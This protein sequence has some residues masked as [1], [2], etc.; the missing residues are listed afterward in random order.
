MCR[1]PPLYPF[2]TY[3]ESYLTDITFYS[4]TVLIHIFTIIRVLFSGFISFVCH[5]HFLYFS[6][7]PRWP[8]LVFF[9]SMFLV[10]TSL[11][12]AFPVLIFLSIMCLFALLHS[13]L[14]PYRLLT[15]LKLLLGPRIVCNMLIN[16][17]SKSISCYSCHTVLPITLLQSCPFFPVLLFC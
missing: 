10:P 2:H 12:G 8:Y 7:P 11:S 13:C 9:L 15:F 3:K 14:V 4:N 6:I 1:C 5:V 16:S 17:V